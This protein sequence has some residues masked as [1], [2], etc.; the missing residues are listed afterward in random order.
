[1]RKMTQ[2][3]TE[4]RKQSEKAENNDEKSMSED[5]EKMRKMTQ[6]A[7]EMMKQSEKAENNDEKSD[8]KPLRLALGPGYDTRAVTRAPRSYHE[9]VEK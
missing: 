2:T 9:K 1:M 7:T 8:P 6:T 5:N 4:M 3:A